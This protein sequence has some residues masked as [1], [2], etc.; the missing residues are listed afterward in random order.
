MLD[1]CICSHGS[2]QIPPLVLKLYLPPL[3]TAPTMLLQPDQD[4]VHQ[5]PALQ[6]QA[7]WQL[8]LLPLSTLC[9][10]P[11]PGVCAVRH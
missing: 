3:M 6:G 4:V 10:L 9:L 8:T 7:S 2:L 1:L 5:V 11:L